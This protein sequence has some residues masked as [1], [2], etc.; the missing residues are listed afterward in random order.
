LLESNL[1][2]AAKI[3]GTDGDYD[4][5][6]ISNESIILAGTFAKRHSPIS[7]LILDKAAPK[8]TRIAHRNHISILAQIP[9]IKKY[10]FPCR[11]FVCGDD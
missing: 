8:Q 3:E 2:R 5:V 6:Q 7:C 4:T 1:G 9:P 11:E 10:Y